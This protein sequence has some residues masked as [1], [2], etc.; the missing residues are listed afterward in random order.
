M[1]PPGSVAEVTTRAEGSPPDQA[2]APRP[3]GDGLSQRALAAETVVVVLLAVGM[4]GL[5]AFWSLVRSLTAEQSL[6]S[7]SAVLNSSRAP[8][9]PWIDLGYQ[10][11]SILALLLPAALA[12]LLVLRDGGRLADIGLVGRRIGRQVL[13]GLGIAAVIGGIGLAAYLISYAAGTSLTVVPTN[14]PDVWWR[15]PVL[16]LSAC[17]NAILE[18]VVLC[19]YLLRRLDQLGVSSRTAVLVSASI[20]GAYHLYQG[21]AGALGNFL[22]GL[23][24]GAYAER[25]GRIL[26]LIVAHAAIDIVAFVGW[27]LLAGRVDWL[28]QP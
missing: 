25:T 7:Q 14:L 9:R 5:R 20:R 19:G 4:S 13:T 3:P 28:P 21:L 11:L 12:V 23:L 17:A 1:L 2:P 18:E 8:G 6:S 16:V 22:M 10:L 26:P 15:I 27:V 24:F